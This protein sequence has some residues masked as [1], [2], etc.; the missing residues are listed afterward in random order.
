MK[1]LVFIALG[2]ALALAM[3]VPAAQA[4]TTAPTGPLADDKAAI[5]ADYQQLKQDR[6]QAKHDREQLRKDRQAGNKDAVEQDVAKL[7]QDRAK[8][9]HDREQLR[10]DREKFRAE[11]RGLHKNGGPAGTSGAKPQS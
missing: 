10:K 9:K 7:K 8:L 4:Q 1:R 5:K 6:K 3:L 11:H 2:G